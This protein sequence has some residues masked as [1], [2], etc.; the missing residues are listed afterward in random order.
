MLI[1]YIM[2][3][4]NYTNYN[5]APPGYGQESLLYDEG[6]GIPTLNENNMTFQDIYR[7]PFLFLQ[8]H[9]KNYKNLSK[10]ALK[11]IQFDSELSKL[12]FSDENIKRIQKMIKQE[13][14]KR[15]KGQFK[16]DADQDLND[17][18]IVMRAIYLE[19]AKNLPNKIVHQVKQ[20][21]HKVIDSN[22][23]EI[24][25][26]IKQE[27]GYLRDINKPLEPIPRPM[28]INRGGR[29]LLPSLTTTFNV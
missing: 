15:T 4:Q 5:T 13:V 17:I 10:N 12:F 22:V 9:K 25:T 3:Y 6:N 1:K 2:N 18:F 29:N 26:A 7:T 8:E 11:G 27:Y 16:L 14:F 28:N 21:N 23:P 20:L 24:I 19:H